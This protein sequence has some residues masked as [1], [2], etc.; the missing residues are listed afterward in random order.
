M[1]PLI[2]CR[3]GELQRHKELGPAR[4]GIWH[5]EQADGSLEVRR[6]RGDWAP[7][8]GRQQMWARAS[9]REAEAAVGC[10]DRCGC[11]RLNT[12]V[13]LDPSPEIGAWVS[14]SAQVKDYFFKIFTFKMYLE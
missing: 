12:Y 13:H 10:D 11:G 9:D 1:R 14:F 8:A 2:R 7:G 5:S 4:G 3:A 6:T